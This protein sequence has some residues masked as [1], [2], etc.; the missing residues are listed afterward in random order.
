[1]YQVLYQ[2]LLQVITHF[3]T[4]NTSSHLWQSI[5]LKRDYSENIQKEG[6]KLDG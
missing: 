6:L 1:M 2:V 3:D 4:L 5:I